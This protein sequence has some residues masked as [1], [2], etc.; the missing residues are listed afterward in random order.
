MLAAV[1]CRKVHRAQDHASGAGAGGG[2]LPRGSGG[3]PAPPPAAAAANAATFAFA[4]ADV[5]ATSAAAAASCALTSMRCL[6]GSCCSRGY[7]KIVVNGGSVASAGALCADFCTW[8]CNGH[9]QP[10]FA[11]NESLRN[12]VCV[13]RTRI[14][15]DAYCG[16]PRLGE[17]REAFPKRFKIL[18]VVHLIRCF[19]CTTTKWEHTWSWRHADNP[20][21]ATP[22]AR[23]ALNTYFVACSSVMD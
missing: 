3:P 19:I 5:A 10:C 21:R 23:A 7:A 18:I 12:R 20:E 6:M 8:R 11:Q 16:R 13:P 17:G 4:F 2:A 22:N 1:L 15:R 9:L 14:L